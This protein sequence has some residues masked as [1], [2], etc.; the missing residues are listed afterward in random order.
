LTNIKDDGKPSVRLCGTQDAGRYPEYVNFEEVVF[1]RFTITAQG[2]DRPLEL[3]I[4]GYRI[5]VS[6]MDKG[7]ISVADTDGK[8]AV[9]YIEPQTTPVEIATAVDTMEASQVDTLQTEILQAVE[10]EMASGGT[11]QAAVIHSIE[12]EELFQHLVGL[13]KKIASEL[14]LPPYIIFHDKTLHDMCRLLPTDLDTLST[15]P[16][17]G[18]AK[19]EK[20]GSWFIQVIQ[21]YVSHIKGVA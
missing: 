9:C 11:E 8:L 14:K 15:V 19:L 20:Y 5:E 2:I 17:V 4:R 3:D 12:T 16:G 18:H 7:S 10:P 1:M 6:D 13:R 21:E